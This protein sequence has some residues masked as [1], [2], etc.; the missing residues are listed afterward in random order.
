MRISTYRTTTELK[1]E[2][3]QHEEQSDSMAFCFPRGIVHIHC[4]NVIG[5]F[6]I[7]TVDL[8]ITRDAGLYLMS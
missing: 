7:S 4:M 5:T 3:L 2:V 8:L 1:P 6:D